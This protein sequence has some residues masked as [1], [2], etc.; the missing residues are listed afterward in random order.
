M[1]TNNSWDSQDPVQ[2]TKGGTGISTA[3][4]AYGVLAAGTTATGPFQNIGTGA[5]G[6]ILTSNG[7]GALPTFQAAGGGGAMVLLHTITFNNTANSY[8]ITPF[9]TGYDTYKFI[10]NTPNL[11]LAANDYIGL[12]VSVNGG[13]SFITTNYV[14]QFGYWDGGG[15]GAAGNLNSNR[16]TI[17]QVNGVTTRNASSEITILNYGTSSGITL[18]GTGLTPFTSSVI[19]FYGGYYDLATLNG[20]RIFTSNSANFASGKFSIYGIA[21]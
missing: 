3:T 10:I 6:E 18:F 13:T 20:L 1:P 12:Q 16:I 2:V 14:E 4:T 17:L 11:A 21:T 5:S 8:D 15:G 9:V 19:V 7:A